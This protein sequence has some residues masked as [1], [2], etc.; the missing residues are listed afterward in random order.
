AAKVA[1]VPYVPR[2]WEWDFAQLRKLIAFTPIASYEGHR[3][4]RYI[5]DVA[6]PQ[7]DDPKHRP[8]RVLDWTPAAPT[9]VEGRPYDDER[10]EPFI[11]VWRR[12]LPKNWVESYVVG[13]GHT[14]PVKPQEDLVGPLLPVTLECRGT[15]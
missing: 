4:T 14:K 8:V 11:Q 1:P 5:V 15:Y 13:C 2:F 6:H 7:F 12:T 3:L 10:G 9:F